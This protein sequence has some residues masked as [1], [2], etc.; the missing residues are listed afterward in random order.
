[1]TFRT[2]TELFNYVWET[3]P[4]VSELTGAPLL[5]K[6]NFQWVWQFLHVLGGNYPHYKLNPDN[7]L[8]G[9]PEEH[10]N[11]NQYKVFNERSDELKREYY[12]RYYGK[13]FD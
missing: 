13:S 9:L 2:K 10:Q 5:P 11:Q 3:R 7:I 6:G 12:A 1:M 8:L 4:H